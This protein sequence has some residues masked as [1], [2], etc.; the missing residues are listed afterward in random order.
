M[1]WIVLYEKS[2]KIVLTSK[3]DA[4]SGLLPKG[5]YIT[6]DMSLPNGRADNRKF[7]LRVEES[8]QTA[9]Y[10]PSPLLA[11]LNLGL[12]EADR[13]CKNQITAHRIYDI[14]QREDGLVD[15]I[16]PQSLARLSNENE[17][18]LATDSLNN[19][20]P[21]LFPATVHSSRCQKIN[22]IAGRP[23]KIRIPEDVYWHQIQITGKTGSG[24]T[25]AT[26]YLAQE[27]IENK[28]TSDGVNRYGCVL[29]I[30]VKDTD[31]LKMDKPTSTDSSEA[32]REWDA[33]G[34]TPSGIQNYEIVYSAHE[35]VKN[36]TNQGVGGENCKMTPI[37]LNASK[38]DPESL[39][40][41][42]ENLTELASQALPDIYRY[43]Q[44]NNP[45]GKFSGFLDSLEEQKENDNSY[46][47]L[48]VADRSSTTKLNPSTASAMISR[49]KNASRYFE[50]PN[51]NEIDA[52][53]I[54]QE[55][56]MTVI[57][58][59][60][61]IEFGSIVLRYLLNKIVEEKTEKNNDI[62]ILII[63]DEVHQFYKSSASKNALGDLDTIC[64]VG[65]SK[66]IG[67]VFSSQNIN[68]IPGGLTSVINTKLMFKTDE[69][70]KKINGISPDDI[71]AM[72]AGYCVTNIHGLPQLKLAKFPLSKSGVL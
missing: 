27:F 70:N 56:K 45:S 23:V 31:F 46:N 66:K 30:N 33:L 68:D 64:R 32:K 26:K 25:V 48:D 53:D 37:T 16:P 47:T 20:G 69:F 38:I 41:I 40:G 24:K 18:L 11:D 50:N 21:F 39:L 3:T 36:L 14:T 9:I 52:S 44:K 49:L 2:G 7:V 28:V 63:I 42:V 6:V 34:F 72:K 62:P 29:A 61:S 19:N 59:A 8:E 1:N 65:R 4:N 51:G 43:W 22:D 5:S 12:Q 67:V 58:V 55:G 17:I 57:D 10:S 71:Q 60:R 35:N 54:L 15:Y 13:V